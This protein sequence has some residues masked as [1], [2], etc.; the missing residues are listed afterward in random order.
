MA[1]LCSCLFS[2]TPH[3]LPSQFHPLS[4]LEDVSLF[5]L[6]LLSFSA[7][8]F[9]LLPLPFF[10]SCGERG[11]HNKAVLKIT[12]LIQS[13]DRWH[14]LSAV[15][16]ISGVEERGE[17]EQE[18]SRVAAQRRESRKQ[19]VGTAGMCCHAESTRGS[20]SGC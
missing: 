7:L 16:G 4:P 17:G 19:K 5:W 14:H 1:G 20:T 9:L 10:T 8:G 18:H 11:F 12:A 6:A 13:C 3:P 2:H 15:T